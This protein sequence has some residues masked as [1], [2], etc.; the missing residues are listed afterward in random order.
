MRLLGAPEKERVLLMTPPPALAPCR[1][2]ETLIS[3]G[4]APGAERFPQDLD[5]S[6]EETM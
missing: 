5:L 3:L 6:F 2:R 4:K 1:L